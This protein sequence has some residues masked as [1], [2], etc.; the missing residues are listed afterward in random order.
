[1]KSEIIEVKEPD[2]EDRAIDLIV[3]FYR[4]T[5]EPLLRRTM[6]L[7]VDEYTSELVITRLRDMTEQEIINQSPIPITQ[8]QV[9]ADALG[10]VVIIPG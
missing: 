8:A 4:D 6:I 1:M 10:Q 7:R 9:E 2:V 5:G 3:Q